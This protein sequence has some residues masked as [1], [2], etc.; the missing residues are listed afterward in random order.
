M[1]AARGASK[2]FTKN[3]TI[4]S[5]SFRRALAPA[6][7]S[8]AFHVL[9]L[10]WNQ[11]AD[12]KPISLQFVRNFSTASKREIGTVTRSLKK[13]DAETVAKIQEE[14]N[15]VDTNQ[16]GR[17][18][19]DELKELL[20]KHDATFTGE[21]I[22]EARELFYT[23]RAGGSLSFQDFI[24]V[25]DQIAAKNATNHPILE[26][27][28]SVEYIYRKSHAK[29][30]PEEL[31][32]EVTHRTPEN[33]RD[34]V[35]LNSVKGV[36][37][38]FDTFTGW[39]NKQITKEKVLRRV[40][41]LETI[42]AVPGFV[43]AI[44]RHFKSLRRMERDGGLLHLFL[45]EANNERMHL[46]SFIKMRDP[47][48]LFRGAVIFS[49]F[50]FG[51]AFLASYAVSPKFCHRFVGYI[52]EEACATYTKI[53]DTIEKAPEGSDLAGWRTEIAPKIA[54]GYW[55]LGEQGT[56]LDLMYAV[57]A[58]EA[59]HRDVNH[60]T[61]ELALGQTNPYN[62]PEMRVSMILRKYVKDI[63]SRDDK[64]ST[65]A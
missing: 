52:E 53:I 40:I 20:K 21:E 23:G 31:D 25:L 8:N 13:L 43:A 54:L 39:N 34:R 5:A 19:A 10:S 16:D 49:Q 46:L 9:A 35:A 51:S 24:E 56:V 42:A 18:D 11:E 12:Q 1:F 17:L 6:P 33:L 65:A 61:S 45:E 38:L 60:A 55:E 28:C 44:V 7:L 26:G 37:F 64:L 63:M 57:R 48:M 29:Y 41:F 15:Q 27:N 36:R 22:L 2:A 59:E 3:A 4:S 58:D 30:S 62:D 50:G 47:G 32:I 14:L